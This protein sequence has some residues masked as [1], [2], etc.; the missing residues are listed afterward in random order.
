ML[1]KTFSL[2]AL[3]TIL[4]GCASFERV[5]AVS[6]MGNATQTTLTV[7]SAQ[8][9]AGVADSYRSLGS[10]VQ[11][12]WIAGPAIPLAREVTLPAPL[13]ANV[14]TTLLFADSTGD[15]L[16]VAERIQRA[17]GI[18]VQVTPDAIL[19]RD[20]FLP[21]LAGDA[22]QDAGTAQVADVHFPGFRYDLPTD[23][24][25]GPLIPALGQANPRIASAPAL[26]PHGEAPLANVLDMV[27]LRLGTYWRYD[28]ELGAIV[29]YR[30]ETRQFNVRALALAAQ[31]ELELGLASQGGGDADSGGGA[32]ESRSR[33]RFTS[34][35]SDTPTL[36]A[37]VAKVEQFLT[38][39]ARSLHLRAPAT[40][41]W[42]RTPKMLS[43]RSR[44]TWKPRI[45]R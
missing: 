26:L 40:S 24:Q 4:S 3:T 2:V 10:H 1:T 42:P 6:D 11:R 13:R 5:A 12:P 33:S 14:N 39:R 17:T 38:A 29:I 16:T 25:A 19:P 7:D 15:L 20:R 27:S 43:T 18:P 31:T 35:S 32:F 44:A 9:R 36:A 8:F 23:R 28:A 34:D 45:A 41:S 37:V 22:K 21:R 30:T